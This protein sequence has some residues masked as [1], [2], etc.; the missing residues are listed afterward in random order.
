[1]CLCDADKALYPR[2]AKPGKPV[3]GYRSH[4]Y[5]GYYWVPV[6]AVYAG[7]IY[8][9]QPREMNMKVK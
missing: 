7:K 6:N 2:V 9:R 4:G 1:M 3:P 8:E 5:L